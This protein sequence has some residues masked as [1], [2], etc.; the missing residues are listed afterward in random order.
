[1]VIKM[2]STQINSY[3]EEAKAEMIRCNGRQIR[4]PCR[5]CKFERLIDPDSGQLEEHLLRR[6]FMEGFD[7]APA[8]NVVPED[9]GGQDDRDEGDV[10]GHGGHDGGGEDANT[11]QSS[12]M[13]G[14]LMSAL[15]DPHVQELLAKHASTREKAKLAQMEIDGKTPLYPGCR[16]QDTRL[17]VTLDAL[18]MKS[19]N[20]WTDTSFNENMQ[21]FHERLPKGN[22][23]PTTIEEA[24]KVV[25]PLDLPHVKYHAC[26]ND[27]T[28]YRGKY[29]DI[30]TY[31]SE[32]RRVG[33][34]C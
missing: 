17:Q 7:Q 33:K 31:R 29:E 11:P 4:C 12:L 6:G 30:T 19:G 24:K 13:S 23:L 2:N 9:E 18:E 25:C 28:I 16:P 14:S 22:T 1:M 15:M 10:D 27:C 3:K 5:S 26:I 32:E 8:A 20:K 21:F 34:E